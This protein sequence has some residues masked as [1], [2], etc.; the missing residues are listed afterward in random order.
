MKR[1]RSGRLVALIAGLLAPLLG[2]DDDSDDIFFSPEWRLMATV[3]KANDELVIDATLSTVHAN[4]F[5]HMS[6]RRVGHNNRYPGRTEPGVDWTRPNV[7]FGETHT[8][9]YLEGGIYPGGGD[10]SRPPK[11]FRDYTYRL[12]LSRTVR[13]NWPDVQGSRFSYTTRT[14]SIY[15]DHGAHP[16]FSP[17]EYEI[18]LY[19]WY[20]GEPN[21]RHPAVGD[22]NKVQYIH[23]EHQII[24]T[25]FTVE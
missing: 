11:A 6:I 3:D 7:W 25:R 2:C 15:D 10:F 21:D 14:Y 1:R 22:E 18:E 20:T 13:T 12:S 9:T 23:S 24:T 19:A 17:G 8:D 5:I 16:G 4:D